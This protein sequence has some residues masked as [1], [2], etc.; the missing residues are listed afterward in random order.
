MEEEGFLRVC[1]RRKKKKEKRENREETG[2]L[3][4]DGFGK[5]GKK[6]RTRQK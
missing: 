1:P 6:K 3:R 5:K 4:G 2:K